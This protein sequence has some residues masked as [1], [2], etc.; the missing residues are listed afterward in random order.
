MYKGLYQLLNR[1]NTSSLD[2]GWRVLTSRWMTGQESK[3]LYYCDKGSTGVVGDK[4]ILTETSVAFGTARVQ[5]GIRLSP[6]CPAG[7]LLIANTPDKATAN[8]SCFYT[9]KY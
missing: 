2:S 3:Q 1:V 5:T 8:K 7:Y 6:C 9:T 4:G